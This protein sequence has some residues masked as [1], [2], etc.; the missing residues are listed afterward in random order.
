MLNCDAI[1]M[2]PQRYA[3]WRNIAAIALEVV[4]SCENSRE[5]RS[6]NALPAAA[7]LAHLLLAAVDET[8]LL[9]A[10][11]PDPASIRIEVGETLDNLM[12]ACAR[13]KVPDRCDHDIVKA[14]GTKAL[15]DLASAMSGGA[16]MRKSK[17]QTAGV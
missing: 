8:A 1:P 15:F 11:A 4:A 9:I 3:V 17:A 6:E 7:P 10:H 13:C 2:P 14:S 5:M 12:E 16:R